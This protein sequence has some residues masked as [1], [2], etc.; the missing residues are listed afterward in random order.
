MCVRSIFLNRP[1]WRGGSQFG[2][3][4]LEG[5]WGSPNTEII[6]GGRTKANEIGSGALTGSLEAG[7]LLGLTR[8]GAFVGK[9]LLTL[10]LSGVVLAV[11]LGEPSTV[12]SVFGNSLAIDFN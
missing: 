10:V 11:A 5:G 4:F 3:A 8:G 7:G 9:F 12:A 2:S 1:W 6:S